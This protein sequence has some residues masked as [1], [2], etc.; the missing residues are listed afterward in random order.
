MN[1]YI[2]GFWK[3]RGNL[4]ALTAGVAVIHWW[5]PSKLGGEMLEQGSESAEMRTRPTGALQQ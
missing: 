4:E 1:V 2:H 3:G 5:K